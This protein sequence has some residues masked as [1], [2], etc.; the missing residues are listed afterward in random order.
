M[1]LP[2]H[3][4]KLTIF[5]SCLLF[6]FCL[7]QIGFGQDTTTQYLQK[8]LTVQPIDQTDW[9]E[10]TAGLDYGEGKFTPPPKK[11]TANLEFLATLF[12]IIGIL[13]VVVAVAFLLRYFI[14]IQGMQK[15][16]NKKFDP[17]AKIDTQTI[18]EHIH[19]FDLPTLIQQAIAQKDFTVATRLYYLLTIKTLSDKNLIHWKKDKT[20]R[21]YLNELTTFDLKNQFSQLTNIFERVWYGEVTVNEAIFGEI[22]GQFKGFTSRIERRVQINRVT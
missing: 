4:M 1:P 11:D 21:N 20:N 2:N 15:A 8:K 12:K 7:P 6:L 16:S 14:G 19:E 22:E 5:I 18:A 13:A 10:A 3:W 17:N 9:E